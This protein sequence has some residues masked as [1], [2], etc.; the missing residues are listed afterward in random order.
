[1]SSAAAKARGRKRSGPTSNSE[2]P[3]PT[4]RGKKKIVTLAPDADRVLRKCRELKTQLQQAEPMI[5]PSAIPDGIPSNIVEVMEQTSDQV[6]EGIEV[7]ALRI[8][9]QVLKRH[10]GF[11]LDIPSRAASNQIYVKEWDRIVLGG[12]RSTRT[13]LQ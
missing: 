11:S 13:F 3:A 5:A 6:L 9:H 1:M 12:K 2:Q 8:A 7:I 10:E 4:A